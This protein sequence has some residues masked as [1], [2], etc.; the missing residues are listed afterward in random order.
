[1]W[2]GCLFGMPHKA[3]ASIDDMS[4]SAVVYVMAETAFET[5]MEPKT[6][7]VAEAEQE[8]K[9]ER[10]P[11]APLATAPETSLDYPPR[12]SPE[13]ER[14]TYRVRSELT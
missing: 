5:Y 4:S 3:A 11:K 14:K 9:K 10:R 7:A 1:M 8:I 2:E 13:T 6:A 12:C